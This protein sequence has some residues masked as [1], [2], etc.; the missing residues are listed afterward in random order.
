MEKR[1]DDG[2][3]CVHGI[4]EN[5]ITLFTVAKLLQRFDVLR[6]TSLKTSKLYMRGGVT[7]SLC[8]CR[9]KS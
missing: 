8:D 4:L 9:R 2:R 1:G 3:G 6:I 5:S 7:F